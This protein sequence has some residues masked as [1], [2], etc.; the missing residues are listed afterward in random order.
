MRRSLHRK[1]NAEL[2]PRLMVL[3]PSMLPLPWIQTAPTPALNSLP[4]PHV[5]L[6]L[7]QGSKARCPRLNL[8]STT[9]LPL[10]SLLAPLQ[11]LFLLRS[12]MYQ[13]HRLD[14]L[15]TT[16]GLQQRPK[17]VPIL[18]PSRSGFLPQDLDVK[19]HQGPQELGD[20]LHLLP[21]S[22]LSPAS[23]Q[24]AFQHFNLL[25]SRLSPPSFLLPYRFMQRQ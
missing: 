4:H 2:F 7:P 5:V 6:V 25:Y 24:S 18:L 3:R 8:I 9:S 23:L 12:L 21:R 10:L 1:G 22:L 11:H 19:P 14:H 13:I 20:L 17:M 16:S 15:K